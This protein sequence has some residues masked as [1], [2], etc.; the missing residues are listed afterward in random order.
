MTIKPFYT[1]QILAGI[2]AVSTPS[3]S[4]ENII[5]TEES[6]VEKIKITADIASFIEHIWQESPLI[7]GAEA[8]MNAARYQAKAD[9]KWRYNPE[10]GFEVVDKDG[11]KK[12]KLVG[13]SQTIDWSGK[14]RAAEKMANY[15]LQVAIAER[16]N[17]RQNIATDVLSALADYQA[18]KEIKELSYKRSNLMERFTKLAKKSFDAG[19]IDQSEHNLAQL[20]F[21]ESLIQ[22]ADAETILAENKI[23]LESSIG[24]SANYISRLPILSDI[25]PNITMD[26]GGAIEHLVQKL[27]VIRILQAQREASKHSISLAKKERIPDPTLSLSGGSDEGDNAIGVAVSI[28]LNIFNSYKA[29]VNVEKYKATEQEKSLQSVFY[30]RK[31]LFNNSK[32]SYELSSRAWNVWKNSGVQALEQQVDTLDKKFKVGDLSATDYLVQIQQTLDTE[33]AAK[34]LHAKAWKSW[35]TWLNASGKIEN[36]LATNSRK[37]E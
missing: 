4:Q 29:E 32:K 24:F 18:S 6:K 31:S 23:A 16:D 27:P 28:P 15:E 11:V 22:Q 5:L 30:I 21:S 19:D 9:S 37:G 8:K 7:H 34:Q 13:I 20:A 2:L 3:H 33:I 36:W 35:F 26:K 17:T 10:I 1:A 14:F 12:S 25:L